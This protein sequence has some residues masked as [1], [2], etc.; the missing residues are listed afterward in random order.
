MKAMMAQIFLLGSKLAKGSA[1]DVG[2]AKSKSNSKNQVLNGVC[3]HT[4]VFEYSDS[5]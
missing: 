2:I 3:C 5:E 4:T 1:K